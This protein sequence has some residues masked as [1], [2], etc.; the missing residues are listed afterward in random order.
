MENIKAIHYKFRFTFTE[1]DKTFNYEENMPR[2]KS[3]SQH[4]VE[5]LLQTYTISKMTGGIETLN[6]AGDKTWCHLHLHFMA[7]EARDTIARLI[8]RYLSDTYSQ[9]VVGVKYFCLK[10]DV[11]RHEDEF[12]RYCL[13]Q[14]FNKKLCY[15]LDDDT[16]Q[17]YHQAAQSSY[18]KCQEINQKKIDKSDN[19]DTMFQRLKNILTKTGYTTKNALL[20]EATKFYVSEDKPLNRITIQGYVDT[21]MLQEKLITYEQ[22]WNI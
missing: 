8:K 1:Q 2:W 6:R 3:I 12:F 16:L 22:Y 13:K 10:P 7:T 5:K 9:Q 14:T 21:Y 17:I 18:L 19:S 11:A 20:I 4:L 15:G